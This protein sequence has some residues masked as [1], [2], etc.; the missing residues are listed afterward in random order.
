ML[1]A[2]GMTMG[3]AR[4]LVLLVVLLLTGVAGCNNDD[5]ISAQFSAAGAIVQEHDGIKVA[6]TVDQQG[7]VRAAV[8]GKDGKPV[9]KSLAGDLTWNDG[10][11]KEQST[12]LKLD[13]ATG[14][15]QARRVDLPAEGTEVRYALNVKG[16]AVKGELDV[17]R[18]AARPR[19]VFVT[20]SQTTPTVQAEQAKA[21]PSN[22]GEGFTPFGAKSS[23]PP[24]DKCSPTCTPTCDCDGKPIAAAKCSPTC[25]PTCDCD[26]NAIAPKK[27]SP[28]CTPTCDCDGNAIAPKKCSPTCTP[29]CDCDGNAIAPKKCSPTCTATCDCSGNAIAPKK[30]APTCTATC[31]CSGNAIA[32]PKCSPTCTATC[33]CSGN[34]IK[35]AVQVQPKGFEPR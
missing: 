20:S 24:S 17:P 29:T 14:L 16:K 22:E 7:N 15:L 32:P 23:E 6:W 33:D 13:K 26:G 5:A 1:S 30:C 10:D 21:E 8:I 9:R 18:V 3:Y 2:G 28:T 4:G 11:G 12:K 19:S 25:T 31:D 27:C 35:K 34:P